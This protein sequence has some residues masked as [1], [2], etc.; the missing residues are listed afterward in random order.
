MSLLTPPPGP[1]APSAAQLAKAEAHA[2]KAAPRRMAEQIVQQWERSFDMLWT[3][4]NG[5][6]PAMRLAEIGTAAA[7]LFAANSALVAFLVGILTGKDD[8]LVARIMAKVVT[9]P[10]CTTHEDGSIT[11]D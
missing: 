11:L 2:I 5:V 9:I 8:A 6:T 1:P 4:R 3:E 7:E 10:P